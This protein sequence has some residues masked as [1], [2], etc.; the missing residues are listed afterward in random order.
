M[1]KELALNKIHRLDAIEGLKRLSDNSIDLI[2]TDPPYNIGSKHKVTKQRGKLMS[3]MQA[4]GSWDTF[5]PFD[6][7]IFIMQ[8]L[9]ECYRVLKKGGTLYMFTAKEDNGFFI[10]KARERGFTF[11]TQLAI[12]KKTPQPS[13]FKNKWRGAFELCLCV[14]KDKPKTFN[15][16]SQQECIDVFPYLNTRRETLHPTEK[17]LEFIKRII[18]VSSNPGDVVLDPFMGSGTTAVACKELKR[19]FQGFELNKDY[20]KMANERMQ[21]VS[22]A[23]EAA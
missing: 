18:R 16:L 14:T 15:F 19:R 23:E 7:D 11:K 3:T 20:I 2:V 17:P 22:R 1:V 5:H 4:W 9:S 13:F 6:Y 8:V 12:I 10:R 21:R